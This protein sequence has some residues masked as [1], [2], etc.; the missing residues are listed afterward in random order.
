MAYYTKTV[1]T[2]LQELSS[3]PHGLS[4]AE[5]SQRLKQFGPNVLNI[6][7]EPLWKKIVEPFANLFM[8]VLFAAMLASFWH[9]EHIDAI[10]VGVIMMTNAV[11]FYVQKFSTERILRA[12]QKK[13]SQRVSVFRDNDLRQLDSAEL[14]PGDVITLDEGEK[15]PADARLIQTASLRIDESQMTGES[16]PI[17]KNTAELSNDKEIYEQTNMVFQGS[18]VIGGQATA[19]IT[20]TGGNTE[21]GKLAVLSVNTDD[22]SPV[23]KR[24]DH[25]ISVLIRVIAVI[26]LVAFALALYRGMDLTEAIRYVL[27]L[28][29]SAVPE[30]LPVAITVVLV[31]GMRR[32]ARKQ[33]LVKSPA[34]IETIGILTFVASDKTGTLTKNKLTV[35]SQWAANT[36]DKLQLALQHSALPKASKSQDPLDVA[37]HDYLDATNSPRQKPEISMT[38]PFDQAAAMSGN[39]IGGTLWVKGSPEHVIERSDL[40]ETERKQAHSQVMSMAASG[41]RVLATARAQV[42]D[43]TIETF[44]DVPQKTKFQLDGLVGVADVLR[45]EAKAAIQRAQGAGIQVCMVT[46]DHFETAFHI[47]KQLGIVETREEVFDSRKIHALS[48]EEM[49][50]LVKT[51][52]VFARVMPENKHRLLTTL[53]QSHI[54]AMTGDGVNDVPALAGAHVGIAMGS[55]TAIAKEAGDIILLNN[56]FKSIVDAVHEGRTIY[57]NIKRMVAYLLATNGGEVLV[58]LGS[59]VIGIPVPLV[60]VQILWVNLVTDTFMVIPLGLEPGEK[61][62]M[63]TKP[64]KAN[65]PLFSRFMLSRIGLTATTMAILTLSIYMNFLDSHGTAYARTIAFNAL[66]VM[67]WASAFNSRSDYESV[68]SRIRRMSWPFYAGLSAA[69]IS[70]VIAL[71]GVAHDLLHLA[72]VDT[73]DLIMT[74]VLAFA[75][76]IAVIEVHK[77][78]G[79]RFFHKGSHQRKA[80]QHSM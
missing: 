72:P 27:A 3:S 57:A 16:L 1:E 60:S 38:L 26:T 53:K 77:W 68:F 12:L 30:S 4:G 18:F 46:G 59:L 36:E 62:N 48:D 9:D 54:T 22:Q 65:A 50:E 28:S 33:A 10:I 5:A 40:S 32:M 58:A 61:R 2:T 78:V 8:L 21:F 6:K 66:V 41:L 17:E 23:Q 67:Q 31:L 19:V 52:R 15:I 63:L 64:Q 79:R 55:G 76:P 70:Q 11:I 71:S 7:G 20:A 56:N 29:V 49:T 43:K 74:S 34:A 39:I 80:R 51:V 47:G 69:V 44:A 13:D 37:L 73:S 42:G 24:I 35:Q 45:T 75:V 14:V 25:L